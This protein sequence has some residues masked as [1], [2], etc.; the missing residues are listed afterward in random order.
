[1][2]KLYIASGNRKDWKTFITTGLAAT[3]Q[4]LGYATSVYKPIQTGCIEANGFI[5]SPDLTFVKTVDPY[6]NTYFT[7][8]FKSNAEPLIA[9][10]NE[11]EYID[12]ELVNQEYSRI[13]N[14]SDCTLID[15]EGG[16]L[17]PIAPNTQIIDIIK[18]LQIPTIFTIT[19]R[20]DAI[21]DVLLS[22]NLAQEKGI[23]VRGVIINNIKEDCSKEMLTSITRIIEEY[24]NIK[25]L[26]LIPYLGER[27]SPEEL[28]TSILNGIDIESVFNIKIEKLGLE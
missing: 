19:P 13:L 14:S 28:I 1:M 9:A 18:K 22:I 24:T 17:S 3:M 26:G 2:T 8:L 25:I 6:I 12:L 10:E 21:N 20:E 23:E 4:G 16:L 5:Q 27:F 7:Y 11:N 15:G